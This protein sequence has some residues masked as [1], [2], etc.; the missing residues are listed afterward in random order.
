MFKLKLK[1]DA[2]KCRS[3]LRKDSDGSRPMVD[4]WV[5]GG[6]GEVDT[7]LTCCNLTRSTPQGVRRI[8]LA[9]KTVLGPIQVD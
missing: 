3:V 7:G 6:K 9:T 5:G 8:L 4:F 2:E 1:F